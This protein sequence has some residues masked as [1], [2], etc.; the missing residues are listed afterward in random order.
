MAST[1]FFEPAFA[2]LRAAQYRFILALTAFLAAADMPLRFVPVDVARRPGP[3]RD[4]EDDEPPTSAAIALR[5]P[6]SF[7]SN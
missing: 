6:E 5:R 7:P 1:Y 3:R 2:A 4:P